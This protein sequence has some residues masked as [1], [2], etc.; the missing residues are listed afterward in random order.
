MRGCEEIGKAVS[1]EVV[2]DA[3]AREVRAAARQADLGRD[4]L[5]TADVGLGPE[6][7]Q[8]NQVFP[9]HRCRV[10]AQGH[11]GKVQQPSDTE[12]ARTAGEVVGEVF[13]RGT[14]PGLLAM[15][16]LGR[17]RQDA[18]RRADAGDTVLDLSATEAR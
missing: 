5:E 3:S 9:R 13:H 7:V 16:G 6:G 2:E 12:V 1:I 11:V 14:R 15:D 18:T 4:V 17:D 8:T 10:F